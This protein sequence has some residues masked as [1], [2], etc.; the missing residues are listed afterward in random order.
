LF[1]LVP[2]QAESR[3]AKSESLAETALHRR[4]CFQDRLRSAFQKGIEISQSKLIISDVPQN[5]LGDISQESIRSLQLLLENTLLKNH[6][7]HCS[8]P[9]KFFFSKISQNK[10]IFHKMS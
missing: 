5:E 4:P 3:S 8:G 1:S 2:T 9:V 6:M 7:F 10:L